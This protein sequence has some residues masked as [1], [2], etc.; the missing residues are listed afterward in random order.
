VVEEVVVEE[1]EEAEEKDEEEEKEE[2]VEL[3]YSITDLGQRCLRKLWLFL[4]SHTGKKDNNRIIAAKPNYVQI[5]RAK[6]KLSAKNRM[7][8][9]VVPNLV[10]RN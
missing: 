7:S 9:F 8:P 6:L 4:V 3:Q 10:S 5:L 2:K 1:E